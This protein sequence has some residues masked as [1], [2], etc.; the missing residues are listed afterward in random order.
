VEKYKASMRETKTKSFKLIKN[1]N[2]KIED[3]NK[4]IVDFEDEIDQKDEYI[5]KL[6]QVI[7]DK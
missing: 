4:L 7:D 1:Q 3:I 6:K 5:R 2:T